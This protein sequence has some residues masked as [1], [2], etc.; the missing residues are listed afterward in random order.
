MARVFFSYSHDDEQYRDQLEKHLATL[1]HQGLIESW[2][3]NTP[4]GKLLA[5]PC[6][7]KPI[8]TWSNYDEAYTDVTRHVRT[9]VEQM[10]RS[11][12]R[13][14]PSH[15]PP[16]AAIAAR[17]QPITALPRSSNLRQRKDFTDADQDEHLHQ[18]FEFMAQFFEGSLQELPRES[19]CRPPA[20][21]PPYTSIDD[22]CKTTCRLEDARDFGAFNRVY[23]SHFPNGQPARSTTEAR[24]MGGPEGGDRR[25]AYKPKG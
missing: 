23:M 15:A 9:V 2:H 5:V 18:A 3:H 14:Q 16:A 24:L 1:K 25:G 20:C 19:S 4:L 11:A 17:A 12:P 8:V 6:D 22:V 7:G 21:C 10:V 13:E